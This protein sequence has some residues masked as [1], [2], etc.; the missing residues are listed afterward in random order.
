MAALDAM[1]TG[2]VDQDGAAT[3]DPCAVC[4]DC[5]VA[6]DEY[7]KIGC[8][9]VYHA[10]CLA[11]WLK[12]HNTCPTCRHELPVEEDAAAEQPG[13]LPV[14][15]P[16]AVEQ[17]V[18]PA[19]TLHEGNQAEQAAEQAEQAVAAAR[20]PA[21]GGL[22]DGGPAQ[23]LLAVFQ[24][25]MLGALQQAATQ[26]VAGP[27]PA[28]PA[29]PVALQPPAQS[30]RSQPQPQ[31]PQLPPPQFADMTDQLDRQPHVAQRQA[32][33]AAAVEAEEERMLQA[34]IQ[35]SLAAQDPLP[36]PPEQP[37]SDALEAAP[38][39]A[40]T[41]MQM[42]ASRSNSP[43]V[44]TGRTSP[45]IQRGFLCPAASRNSTATA[46]GRSH[47]PRSARGRTSPGMRRGFFGPAP[48]KR[49]AVT[50][51]QVGRACA[52]MTSSNA[53]GN[54]RLKVAEMRELLVSRGVA[55]AAI[56][57]C[58]ERSELEHLLEVN[59]GMPVTETATAAAGA[60]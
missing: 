42:E 40:A 1:E 46:A 7:K 44:S 28:H 50:D 41:G 45:G 51:E 20:Q 43:P 25:Q 57:E 32:R 3:L 56:K 31:P 52:M 2:F 34:A 13:Q 10:D 6:G 26:Q 19:Q 58:V 5:F 60:R 17:P 23:Q 14:Q 29:Q 27:G 39:A 49:T 15:L 24:Q 30:A 37:Q 54:K 21:A 36:L 12:E 48:T 35:M 47:S 18:Q 55:S 16:V 59:G 22:G 4:Q 53:N 8:G 38:A 33:V 9:H 11:P